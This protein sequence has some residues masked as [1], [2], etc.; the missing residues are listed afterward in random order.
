[1]KTLAYTIVLIALTVSGIAQSNGQVSSHTPWTKEDS[2]A[3]NALALYP[4]S[5]RMEIFTACE[6]PAIIVNLASLQ[7][8]SSDA[9]ADLV[10]SYDKTK[11]EDVWN[12]SRYPN[13]IARLVEGGKKSEADIDTILKD[14]PPEIHDVALKYGRSEYDLLNKVDELQNNTNQQFNDIISAYPPDVQK[15]F[16]DLLQLPEVLTLLNDH[17]SLS[18][19]VGDKY[20]RDP[21]WVMH[22]S[23]SNAAAQAKINAEQLNDWK[24]SLQQDSGAQQELQSAANEYAE[25]NGYSDSDVDAP[26]DSTQVNNTAVYPYSYW[27]GYPTW[28]PYAYWYPY[29]YWYDWGFY[30]GPG[31]NMVVFGFPSYYFTN[32]YFYY[33]KHWSRYPHLGSVYIHHYYGPRQYRLNTLSR[34]VVHNWVQANRKYLPAGFIKNDAERVAAMRQYG[35]LNEKTMNKN[36]TVNAQARDQYFAANR[37][38]YPA[39]NSHPEQVKIPA[40]KQAPDVRQPFVK[41]PVITPQRTSYQNQANRQYKTQSQ[42]NQQYRTQSQRPQPAPRYNYNTIQRAQQYQRGSWEQAQPSYHAAPSPPP[43]RTMPAP[44]APMRSGGFGGRR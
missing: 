20:K 40:E 41:E 30:Y 18:V 44:S 15:V 32:W 2:A 16:T 23:D 37:T 7:K 34:E 9:F 5:V 42:T 24:Q 28:Y 6:Y 31:G 36:G 3:I 39:L 12:L 22:K 19:R 33:P 21:Q 26:L 4:D 43:A 35:E 8:N 1:M 25:D 13:L 27:F 14:Y 11:Q 17:L 29:P 10:S 38:K